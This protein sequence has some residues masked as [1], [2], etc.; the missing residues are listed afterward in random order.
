MLGNDDDIEACRGH[1]DGEY[2]CRL[3]Q[4]H[5][6]KSFATMLFAVC[7]LQIGFFGWNC[8]HQGLDVMTCVRPPPKETK[9]L[10]YFADAGV[11]YITFDGNDYRE[12]LWR[13]VTYAFSHKGLEHLFSNVVMTAALGYTLEIV[14][15]PWRFA[16]IW[17]I[18]AIVSA[19]SEQAYRNYTQEGTKCASLSLVGS[20]GAAYGI[21]GV[22]LSNLIKNADSMAI[23]DVISRLCIIVVFCTVSMYEYTVWFNEGIAYFCHFGGMFIGFCLGFTPL[24]LNLTVRKWEVVVS[25]VFTGAG[26]LF[27][28]YVAAGTYSCN[29]AS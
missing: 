12:Q 21:V 24:L 4:Q 1:S 28:L 22:H 8:V 19:L 11:F 9:V 3:A 16:G 29:F 17:T 6:R 13:T 2:R 25:R 5:R 27:S 15:G 14:H 26:V 23:R 20:S 18:C 7:I 10:D